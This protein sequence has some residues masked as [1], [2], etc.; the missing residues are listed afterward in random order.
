MKNETFTKHQTSKLAVFFC[1]ELKFTT[2]AVKKIF[3]ELFVALDVLYSYGI[4]FQL[5]ILFRFIRISV[6]L[7]K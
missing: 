4:G 3:K 6:K 2:L 7:K 5:I 1:A